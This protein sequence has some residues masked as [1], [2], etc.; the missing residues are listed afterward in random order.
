MQKKSLCESIL[1]PPKITFSPLDFSRNSKKRVVLGAIG[2]GLRKDPEGK[3][4]RLCHPTPVSTYAD[5]DEEEAMVICPVPS[6]LPLPF[7]VVNGVVCATETCFKAP[8]M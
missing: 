3:L 4:L 7:K 1:V 5:A 8:C 2:G 6:V